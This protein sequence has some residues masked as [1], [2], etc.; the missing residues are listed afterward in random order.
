MTELETN[1]LIEAIITLRNE[2]SDAT[3]SKAAAVYQKLNGDGSI[4]HAGT[5]IN[6]NSV[7]KIAAVDIWDTPEN[8]PDAAP[9][10]WEDLE[11]RDG[12]RII[13]EVITVAKAF[14]LNELGWWGD[15]VYKSLAETNVYTPEQYAPYWELT[16]I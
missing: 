10:L 3:A 15:D 1:A 9:T 6:W 16:T 2:A 12:I 13:P 5:K 7:V 4:I 11:Y 14:H 8:T